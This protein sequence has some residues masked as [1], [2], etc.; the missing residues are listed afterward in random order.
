VEYDDTATARFSRSVSDGRFGNSTCGTPGLGRVE[1]ELRQAGKR[2]TAWK[3]LPEGVQQPVRRAGRIDFRNAPASFSPHAAAP[4]LFLAVANV[5]ALVF[6][7]LQE[8]PPR[9]PGGPRGRFLDRHTHPGSPEALEGLF[10]VAQE[11]KISSPRR[12]PSS[13][14][15]R[16][17]FVRDTPKLFGSARRGLKRLG[18]MAVSKERQEPQQRPAGPVL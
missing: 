12:L 1:E 13:R 14:V 18:A 9:R 16:K 7:R 4:S 17:M 10:L 2:S 3:T 15:A 8:G 11:M 6:G 5:S